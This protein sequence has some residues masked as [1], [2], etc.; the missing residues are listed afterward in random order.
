MDWV[1]SLAIIL[2]MFLILLLAGMPVAFS[3]MTTNIVAMLL[4]Y[5]GLAGV[6][7]YAVSIFASIASF[8]LVPIPFFILMG[9]VMFHSGIAPKMLDTLDKLLG[10]LPG[11]L[12]VLA[13][14]TGTLLATLTGTGIASTGVLGELLV[15]QMQER[16]YHKTMII[17]PIISSG[18]LAMMIPPSALG[19]LFGAIGEISV[20]QILMG[21]ILPGILMASL[22]GAYIVLR[23]IR[24]PWLAPPYKIERV[25]VSERAKR[26]ATDVLPLAIVIFLV[27]GV[28]F[29]GVASPSEAAATG[30]AGII[31]LC[32]F[33]KKMNW[34]I[35]RKSVNGTLNISVMMFMIVA[36]AQA[37]SQLLAYTGASAGLIQTIIG[38]EVSPTLVFILI[39]VVVLI[40]GTFMEPVSIMMITLPLAMPIIE[41]FGFNTV[42]FA[43]ITLINIDVGTIS[44]PFG[45]VLYVMKGVA[46]PGTTMGEIIRASVPFVLLDL[47]V[48]GLIFVFPRIALFL[49]QSMF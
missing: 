43:V 21:I 14:I 41:A 12:S 28:V 25:T 29:I 46:P 36:G 13:V 6:E 33:Y 31:I 48:M 22:Y 27:I 8:V 3:F 26:V 20:G 2:G 17:G 32:L 42:W 15:P 47:L 39:Q 5:E 24:Q 10:R 19:V 18:C 30:A 40:L 7:Q 45:L 49:P 4:F 34:N 38:L 37:F 9:E 16:G 1:S 11:R 44:P 23:C 35:F